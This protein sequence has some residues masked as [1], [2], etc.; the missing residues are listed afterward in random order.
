ME[1]LTFQLYPRDELVDLITSW[2]DSKM[3]LLRLRWQLTWEQ[4]G[5]M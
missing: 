1:A 5:V 4:E 2:L 3:R